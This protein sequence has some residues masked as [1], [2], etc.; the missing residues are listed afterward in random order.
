MKNVKD[1]EF[2]MPHPQDTAQRSEFITPASDPR[3][4]SSLI[5]V[6]VPPDVYEIIST[7]VASRRFP[8][9]TPSHLVRHAVVR[10]LKYLATLT[11]EEMQ[12]RI[13]V[14]E[15]ISHINAAC[16][17]FSA[18]HDTMEGVTGLVEKYVESGAICEATQLLIKL[19][20]TVSRMEDGHWK[21]SANKI[22][23]DRLNALTTK[24]DPI[25]TVAKRPSPPPVPRQLPD[26]DAEEVHF[27]PD[28]AFFEGH[29]S[30]FPQDL[31]DFLDVQEP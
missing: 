16:E 14:L 25:I 19:Q 2:H 18:F 7:I 22:I 21:E 28:S 17:E 4:N 12:S 9:Q 13:T 24:M 5:S 29:D 11:D 1:M 15:S 23:R 27:T 6:R 26:P 30:F 3:G 20:E 8:Y 10:H 31:G